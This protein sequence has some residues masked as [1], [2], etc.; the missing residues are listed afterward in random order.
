MQ[1]PHLLPQPEHPPKRVQV[2]RGIF[3]I[4]AGVRGILLWI[5]G[6]CLLGAAAIASWRFLYFAWKASGS[7][8]TYIDQNL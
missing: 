8:K 4:L 5:I 3:V 7:A 6:A 2:V 1:L